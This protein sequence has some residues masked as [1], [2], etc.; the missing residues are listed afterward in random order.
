[1]ANNNNKTLKEIF[2]TG[3][4]AVINK[5]IGFE[6]LNKYY[7]IEQIDDSYADKLKSV[8]IAIQ[9]NRSEDKHGWRVSIDD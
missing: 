1:M 2:G 5:I 3:T 8:L 7:N 9:T 4:A 6:H